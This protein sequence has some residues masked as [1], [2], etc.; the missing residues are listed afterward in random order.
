MDGVAPPSWD[1]SAG[2]A[3]RRGLRACGNPDQPPR[4]PALGRKDGPPRYSAQ[5]SAQL[6]RATRWDALERVERFLI[7]QPKN[8]SERC[9]QRAL[10]AL[11]LN[12]RCRFR[13]NLQASAFERAFWGK[14]CSAA[15]C[16]TPSSG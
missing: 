7:G 4:S 3:A 6:I 9:V 14:P 8:L 13:A 15:A 11:W 10:L 16:S 12:V 5:T 2:F 1:C